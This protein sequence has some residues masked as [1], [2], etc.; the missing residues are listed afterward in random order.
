MNI[1]NTN[2]KNSNDIK[3]HTLEVEESVILPMGSINGSFIGDNSITGAKLSPQL[4]NNQL[5]ALSDLASYEKIFK[6][7]PVSGAIVDTLTEN[8]V[9]AT[10]KFNS[11]I[12]EETNPEL[13]FT[14][15]N[16]SSI[17]MNSTNDDTINF[18]SAFQ[19][20]H[21]SANPTDL[22]FRNIASDYSFFKFNL[23]TNTFGMGINAATNLPFTILNLDAD[24]RTIKLP[25]CNNTQ[26]TILLNNLSNGDKGC[27]TFNTETNRLLFWDGNAFHQIGG[28][29]GLGDHT[30]LDSEFTL[31]HVND[32]TKKIN[33][34]LNAITTGT[35]RTITIPDKNI[36]LDDF[37]TKDLNETISG[38]KTFV[39]NDVIIENNRLL[40]LR[41]DFTDSFHSISYQSAGVLEAICLAGSDSSVQTSISSGYFTSNNSSNAWNDKF[42]VRFSNNTEPKLFLNN[43]EIFTDYQT[44]HSNV[45]N[46]SIR[47]LGLQNSSLDMNNNSINNISQLNN[48]TSTELSYLNNVTSD[49]Q[50]QL[51][52]KI[53]VN[54]TNTLT[55]KTIDFSANTLTNV[56]STNTAQNITATKTL[57]EASLRIK[58][59]S[60]T[61]QDNLLSIENTNSNNI[62]G[63]Q[64]TNTART[65]GIFLNN[66]T[67][68]PLTV[69]ST[70]LTQTHDFFDDSIDVKNASGF[71]SINGANVLTGSTLGSTVL[72]SSLTSVGTLSSLT[73]GGNINL[74]TNNL[75]NVGTINGLE[76]N[77]LLTNSSSSTLTNKTIDSTNN[78]ISN[79]ALSNLSTNLADTINGKWTQSNSLFGMDTI[80]T[81]EEKLEI[82]SFGVLTVM[83]IREAFTDVPTEY[84]V[85]GTKVVGARQAHIPDTFVGN[86]AATINNILTAL[87]NHGLIAPS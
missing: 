24:G 80:G 64:L 42:S 61:T 49:I 34:N 17:N 62:V 14:A 6:L 36:N 44:L 27:M 12:I 47:N 30:Y 8:Q 39:D 22:E 46:S 50:T 4:N 29:V 54:S 86:E 33:F 73:M 41:N 16:D 87:R 37:V 72:N 67:N 84:R 38:R 83:E 85:S 43:Q 75:T 31:A 55:N 57:T 59:S 2:I 5:Q 23:S 60:A 10:K 26:Q 15:T 40:K 25:N 7:N 79:I 19:I 53:E 82:K 20:K 35:T 1:F 63:F 48:T 69:Y 18:K 13:T 56:L 76:A 11:L 3:C 32:V 28:S 21:S 74:S 70:G 58:T 52:S 71:Y 77:N 81:M 45:I 9:I 51:N 68:N 65:R 66:S 78:T